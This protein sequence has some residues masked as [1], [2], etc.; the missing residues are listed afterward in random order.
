MDGSRFL[1]D[2]CKFVT[3]I[4]GLSRSVSGFPALPSAAGPG[5][6]QGC[7]LCL[8][9]WCVIPRYY[10]VRAGKRLKVLASGTDRCEMDELPGGGGPS[11]LP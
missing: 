7:L 5:I 1:P 6:S 3:W 4:R 8:G 11:D 10:E 2:P 9:A